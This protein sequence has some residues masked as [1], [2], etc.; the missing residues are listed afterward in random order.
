MKNSTARGEVRCQPSSTSK[1]S[2]LVAA[3]AVASGSATLL[4]VRFL[5]GQLGTVVV[6]VMVLVGRIA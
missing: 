5:P 4:G 1:A 3:D 6:A 2:A